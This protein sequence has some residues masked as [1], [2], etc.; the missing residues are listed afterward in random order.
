[1]KLHNENHNF[2]AKNVL[3][4]YVLYAL[5]GKKIVHR[6]ENAA[7]KFKSSNIRTYLNTVL[8]RNLKMKLVYTGG[9]LEVGLTSQ[10]ES[11]K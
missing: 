6:K 5:C 11:R 2:T 9:K 4:L 8:M 10:S 7:C 1:M 3:N